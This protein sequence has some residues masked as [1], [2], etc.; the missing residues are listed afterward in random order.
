VSAAVAAKPVIDA[1]KAAV[2]AGAVAF[3]DGRKPAGATTRYV[4]AWFDAGTV[5]DRSLRSR[6]GWECV[7]TFHAYGTTPD[8]ARFA[9][10]VLT[11]AVLGLAGQT[12]AGRTVR[13]PEQL[14]ARPLD[15]DDD[16]DPPL[17]DAISEW[18]FRTSP[19]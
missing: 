10:D 15:R 13:M 2:E 12:I 5:T 14:T 16:L 8:A 4:V 1:L 7:G 19:V 6:D 18:R 9:S 11:G 3:G 17:F